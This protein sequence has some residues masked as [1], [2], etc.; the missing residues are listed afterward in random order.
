[1]ETEEKHVVHINN[2]FFRWRGIYNHFFQ[3]DID[4]LIVP[5]SRLP[6][7]ETEYSQVIVAG[8]VPL[9]EIVNVIRNIFKTWSCLEKL[10]KISSTRSVENGPYIVWHNGLSEQNL[11]AGCSAETISNSG[12]VSVTLEE[13]L[14]LL[15]RSHREKLPLII[16]G[17]KKIMCVET[18][19]CGKFGESPVVYKKGDTITID[20]THVSNFRDMNALPLIV[21]PVF[22]GKEDLDHVIW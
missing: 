4:N 15:L 17:G 3:R 1:M 20:A 22:F 2:D 16:D 10:N 5:F 21:N 18:R 13:C 7:P 8:I 14:L 6:Q 19:T 9:P 11:F 12:A